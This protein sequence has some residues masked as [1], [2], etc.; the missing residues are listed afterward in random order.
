[1]FRTLQYRK[2]DL[3]TDNPS[4]TGATRKGRIMNAGAP[5]FPPETPDDGTELDGI[6][7]QLWERD[8]RTCEYDDVSPAAEPCVICCEYS[9]GECS[10]WKWDGVSASIG[11]DE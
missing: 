6:P 4:S 5:C 9:S 3:A 2:Q 10:E 11:D 1:M 8:C 7:L